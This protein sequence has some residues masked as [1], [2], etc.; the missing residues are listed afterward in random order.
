MFRNGRTFGISEQLPTSF[1]INSLQSRTLRYGDAHKRYWGGGLCL[2][3]VLGTSF[4]TLTEEV[5]RIC[6]QWESLI[7]SSMTTD[8]VLD[9]ILA[10]VTTYIHNSEQ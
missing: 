6:L 3:R 2:F 9:W 5:K 1:G 8:G 7:E 4:A 10:L